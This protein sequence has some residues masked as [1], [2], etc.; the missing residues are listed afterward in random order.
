MFVD[1][2]GQV[3]YV[4]CTNLATNPYLNFI[5]GTDEIADLYVKFELLALFHSHPQSHPL[6]SRKDMQAFPR[7]YVDKGLILVMGEDVREDRWVWYNE[8]GVLNNGVGFSGD[9][10]GVGAGVAWRVE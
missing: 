8:S 4:P 3:G 6:P 9:G 2:K 10:A 7:H 1:W 5:I